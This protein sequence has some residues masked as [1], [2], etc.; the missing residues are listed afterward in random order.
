M[1]VDA[2]TTS[3]PSGSSTDASHWRCKVTSENDK[4]AF[5]PRKGRTG[6]FPWGATV[7]FA[8]TEGKLFTAASVGIIAWAL[9]STARDSRAAAAD[10]SR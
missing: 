1:S 7:N 9:A 5:V 2:A 3:P 6:Y 10:T 4:R 8:T